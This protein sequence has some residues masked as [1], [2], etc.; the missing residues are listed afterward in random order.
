MQKDLYGVLGLSKGAS[1]DEIKKAY[2]RLSKE[3]HPDKRKGDTASEKQYKEV[4]EAYEILSNPKKKQAYDQF[5]VTGDASGSPF[6][7][8]G[9]SPFSGEGFGSFGDIF[10][11]FFGGGR[12]GPS[13]EHQRGADQEVVVELDLKDIVTGVDRTISV[14]KYVS[15]S[16]CDGKGAERD[17]SMKTC[18]A[19]GGTGQITR[20]SR[21]IFGTIQQSS[22]CT[23]CEGSGQ[24]PEHPCGNCTGEGRLLE[25]TDITVEIPPGIEDRQTLRVQGKGEVGK[26]GG[27]SGDLYVTVRV[28]P[29]SRF[30][31]EGENVR[32]RLTLSVTDAILGTQ[33]SIETVEG[34][35]TLDVPSGTQPSQVLRLKGKGLPVL[36]SSRR[37][38][39]FVDVS[40]DIPT[41]L[42]RKERQLIEDLKEMQG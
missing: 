35:V 17:S 38:D 37:G 22:V 14:R 33:K 4:N 13:K 25:Q 20:T 1:I 29:D 31:R 5:G 15:C 39:H 21:S 42:S 12:S 41:K 23:T 7:G 11:S 28:R 32:S 8:A 24:I 26:R 19:C 27:Q 18:D 36:S 2:R 3:L 30:I 16:A 10:D 9:F 34:E 6:G 40:V